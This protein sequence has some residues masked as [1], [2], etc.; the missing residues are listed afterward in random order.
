MLTMFFIMTLKMYSLT[1]QTRKKGTKN[2]KH[3]FK[4]ATKLSFEEKLRGFL[5]AM[6]RIYKTGWRVSVEI[7]P[8]LT[9]RI[10]LLHIQLCP[11][12]SISF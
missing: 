4:Y 1:I 11:K 9:E 12:D 10:S 5:L 6:Y 8:Y 7:S 2:V 3:V